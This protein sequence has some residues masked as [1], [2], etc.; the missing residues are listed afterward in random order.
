MQDIK[1]KEKLEAIN[2]EIDH[3]IKWLED[4]IED[5]SAAAGPPFGLNVYK[6]CLENLKA[7]KAGEF[8]NLKLIF[9]FYEQ[10][11]KKLQDKND[12]LEDKVYVL[13]RF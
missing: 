4:E 9:D 6:S 5:I 3:M 13:R 12:E 10:K 11:I 2:Y 8:P 1:M 7:I